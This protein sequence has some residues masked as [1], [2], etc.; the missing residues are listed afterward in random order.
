MRTESASTKI[1]INSESKER[2]RGE[3]G[4]SGGALFAMHAAGWNRVIPARATVARAKERAI[5]WS[6][7]GLLTFNGITI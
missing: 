1:W 5:L 2:G 4:W 6:T 3:W 7:A